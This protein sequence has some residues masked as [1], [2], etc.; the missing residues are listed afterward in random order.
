MLKLT[1]LQVVLYSGSDFEFKPEKIPEPVSE[2]ANTCRSETQA[3]GNIFSEEASVC[4]N[5]M[6]NPN[7][8]DTLSRKLFRRQRLNPRDSKNYLDLLVTEVVVSRRQ[9][10]IRNDKKFKTFAF[11]I[12][13]VTCQCRDRLE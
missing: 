3:T 2:A 4:N 10:P 5:Y 7:A 9:Y 1:S 13:N 8:S 6:D 11:S 12:G